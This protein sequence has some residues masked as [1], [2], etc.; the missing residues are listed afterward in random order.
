[1]T[2]TSLLASRFTVV[3]MCACA[4]ATSDLEEFRSLY[5]QRASIAA[6]RKIAAFMAETTDDYLVRS[7]NGQTMTKEELAQRLA[8]YFRDQLVHQLLFEYGVRRVDVRG[9][10]AVVEVE[11]RDKRIQRRK[12]GKEHL[13]E[14]DVIHT[15]TWVKTSTGW[16]LKFTQ[17]G[18]QLKFAV[19]GVR[20]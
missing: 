7:E 20:Q 4:S 3:L 1:M 10:E 14:A 9:D 6:E 11:Q 15:D 2:Q 17:E 19:D 16:K 18:E 13:V 5:K 12:D 8:T